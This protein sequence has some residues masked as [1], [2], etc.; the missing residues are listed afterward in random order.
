MEVD[1]H[2]LIES[3]SGKYADRMCDGDPERRFSRAAVAMAYIVGAEETLHRICNV[4]VESSRQGGGDC[5]AGSAPCR[6]D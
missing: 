6:A 2:L 5:K 3:L 1:N 4:I